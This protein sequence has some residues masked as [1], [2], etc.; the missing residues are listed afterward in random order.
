MAN[1]V[2]GTN[3]TAAAQRLCGQPCD[4]RLAICI[5]RL[6]SVTGDQVCARALGIDQRQ[7]TAVEQLRSQRVQQPG[8]S[9]ILID[10]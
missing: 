1:V 7:P 4:D 5:R 2:E 9:G 10:P 3:G 8:D 6:K